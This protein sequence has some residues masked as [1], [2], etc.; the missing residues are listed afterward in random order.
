MD[1]NATENFKN[2]REICG[3][4]INNPQRVNMNYDCLYR[5]P[6]EFHCKCEKLLRRCVLNVGAKI[7]LPVKNRD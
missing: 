4:L 5:K 2:S 7:L 1:N 6:T 3:T